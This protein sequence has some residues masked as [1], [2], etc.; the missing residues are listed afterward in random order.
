MKP[1]KKFTHLW[2]LLPN[3]IGFGTFTL[4]PVLLCFL[5]VFS[6]WS[7]KP[8]VK[9]EFVGL[10]NFSDVLGLRALAQPL[11]ALLWG[12]LGC[13][14]AALLGA[15]GLLWGSMRNWQGIKW[16]GALLGALG[17]ACLLLPMRG[18]GGQGVFLSG[19]VA[20]V[21]TLLL[22]LRDEEGGWKPGKGALP[23]LLL[24]AGCLGLWLLDASMWQAYTP[25]DTRFWEYFY[26]T[27]YF[28]LGIPFQI[29][30]SL[31]LALLLYEEF[32]VL[33]RSPRLIGAGVCL[34]L[35][36]F[37]WL[38]LN[39]LG[40]PNA[41]VLAA[42]FWAMGALGIGFGVVAFR[43]IFYLPTFTSGVALMILWKALYNPQSGPINV[44]LAA[45]LHVD[46]ETLPQWL[47]SITWAKPALVVMGVWTGIGGTGMLLY[48]A[49]LSG[50]SRELHEAA[51]VDGAGRWD[52]FRHVTWPSVAPTTFFITVMAII[53]GLQGGF[54]QARV[55]TQGG[56]AATTTTLSYYIYTK[57]FEEFQIGYASAISW[58][59]FA[60]IFAVTLVNWKFGN[61]EVSY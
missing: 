17:L 47:T 38:L 10:R 31:A 37:S 43:T 53:G 25:R 12:Y 1:R 28:M 5:M 24:M 41:G 8:A 30:G 15:L 51:E 50:V 18:Q 9:L 34:A 21:G 23:G 44:G 27:L 35:G 22:L 60:V 14:A 4:F 45:L 54:E 29:M 49:A 40:S 55:M 13:A 32:P 6:N 46:I 7:L 26:N 48:L 59:L 39:G 20:L 11:P 33:G 57:A 42:I 61:R 3:L 2:F 36:L 16:G 52:G 56:P 58:V 19:C